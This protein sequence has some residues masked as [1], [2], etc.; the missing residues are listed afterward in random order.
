MKQQ[1]YYLLTREALLYIF[2]LYIGTWRIP[3]R[4]M[5]GYFLASEH[6]KLLKLGEVD[7]VIIFFFWG[8]LLHSHENDF[9]S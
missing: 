8:H 5:C 4:C 6:E 3:C 7:N 9:Y 2:S 1:F